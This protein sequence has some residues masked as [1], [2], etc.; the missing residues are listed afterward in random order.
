MSRVPRDSPE[1]QGSARALFFFAVSPPANSAS[2]PV[3]NF[4]NKKI[5]VHRRFCVA[6]GSPSVPRGGG[7]GVLRAWHATVQAAREAPALQGTGAP[8]GG[9]PPGPCPCLWWDVC[10]RGCWHD[11]S[12]C[13]LCGFS[14]ER[15]FVTLHCA[16]C[17]SICFML[18]AAI[19]ASSCHKSSQIISNQHEVGD[20]KKTGI[21]S[22][23]H[24]WPQMTTT[25]NH[26]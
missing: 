13:A 18:C 10:E 7:G 21:P 15:L 11:L 4:R 14:S 24:K 25:N 20:N 2:G 8:G 12:R 3:E 16:A 22:N 26:N 5:G 9:P 6:W 23:K 1:A 19:P 17:Q